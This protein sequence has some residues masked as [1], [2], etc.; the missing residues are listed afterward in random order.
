MT[1]VRERMTDAAALLLA[2][3]GYQATSFSAVL[4]ESGAPRGSIY[5]HFPGGKDELVSAALAHQARRVI[6]GLDHLAGLDPEEVVTRFAGWWR[7][8]LESTGFAVG[9]SLVAV[10]TSAGP[11]ALRDEAGAAFARWIAALSGLFRRAGVAAETAT[12]FATQVLAAIEGAV[13]MSRAQGSFT[14]FDTVVER[15][16]RD[17]ARLRE[18]D[19]DG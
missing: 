1:E 16:R 10:T 3:D 12:S 18:G 15:L 4:E 7:A 2:R 13:V 11:G 17:A 19:G 14:V 6:G 5:H 8:G 9:C